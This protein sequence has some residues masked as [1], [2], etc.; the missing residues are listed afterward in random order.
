MPRMFNYKS[1]YG[2][3]VTSSR[4]YYGD[5]GEFLPST[6]GVLASVRVEGDRSII[7]KETREL[8]TEFTE[9]AVGWHVISYGGETVNPPLHPSGRYATSLSFSIRA[10]KKDMYV[11]SFMASSEAPE[12]FAIEFGRKSINLKKLMLKDGKSMRIPLKSTF[13]G[14]TSLPET[15]RGASGKSFSRSD[16]AANTLASITDRTLSG[17]RIM[18]EKGKAKW[19]MKKWPHNRKEDHKLTPNRP[20]HVLLGELLRRMQEI[21]RE[22][23]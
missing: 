16:R 21:N 15:N 7:E 4:G 11:V 22:D 12:A 3:E 19:I 10:D 9:F 20:A 8:F 13:I 14:G 5:K 18:S 23:S 1:Q 17:I 2:Q 6:R